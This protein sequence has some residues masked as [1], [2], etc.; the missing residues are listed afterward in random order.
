MCAKESF[1]SHFF[2][3]SLPL[4]FSKCVF[5][6]YFKYFCMATIFKGFIEFVTL[7]LLFHVWFF[8]PEA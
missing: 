8:G 7:S 4:P 3:K 5:P 6:L 2:F 1:G